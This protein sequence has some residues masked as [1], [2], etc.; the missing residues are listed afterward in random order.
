MSGANQ[1]IPRND[2]FSTIAATDIGLF[3][4]ED[5]STINF[6]VDIHTTKRE[7]N[8]NGLAYARTDKEL[9]LAIL[10][11]TKKLMLLPDLILKATDYSDSGNRVFMHAVEKEPSFVKT[12][13]VGTT[14]LLKDLK[15]IELYMDVENTPIKFG[16]KAIVSG[17][18]L[19]HSL[20]KLGY[21]GKK[22][23]LILD[24]KHLAT[25]IT[26]EKGVFKH[27]FENL[28]VGEHKVTAFADENEIVPKTVRFR[29]ES[30]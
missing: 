12:I 21:Q 11:P 14:Q 4:Q 15:G 20:I 9:R 26:D 24:D 18:L 28:E 8:G 19:D 30:V 3:V 23:Y 7:D 16:D 13:E 5:I 25:K 2:N 17:S 22:V 10:L 6:Y 29:V 27:A 1:E